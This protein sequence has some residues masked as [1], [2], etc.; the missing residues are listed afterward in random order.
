MDV[1]HALWRF[2]NI[3]LF[4]CRA[5]HSPPHAHMSFVVSLYETNLFIFNT[6]IPKTRGI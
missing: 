6:D 5:P 4:V 2:E 3:A 1:H